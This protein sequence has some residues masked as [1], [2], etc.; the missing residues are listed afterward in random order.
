MPFDLPWE[1]LRL[2]SGMGIIAL[3]IYVIYRRLEVRLTLLVA[4]LLLGA[5]AED[6]PA[7]LRK[8]L[9]TFT[10]EKFVVPICTAMGF[11]YVVR[12]T[13]CD[14]HLVQLLL[15]PVKKVRPL[16][17]PGTV[18][19]GF[20]V[21]MPIVSQTST[22]VTIGMVVIPVLAAARISP[23]TIGAAL[24]L[25]CS[26][27]GELLNPGAPELR[28]TVVETEKAGAALVKAGVL[29]QP[30]PKL[31]SVDCVQRVLPLNLLGLAV[32]TAVFWFLAHRAEARNG[33]QLLI[34]DGQPP[35][36]SPGGRGQGE[37]GLVREGESAAPPAE[38]FRVNLL[39]ALVPLLPLLLLY[40]TAEPFQ[41]FD[42]WDWLQDPDTAERQD[43][44]LI[45]AS[46]LVGAAVA[47]LVVRH[48]AAGA[49]SAFFE[50]AGFGF[51]H[52]IS[53]IVAAS[54]F[55]EGIKMIGIA[56]VI[57]DVSREAP[58]LLLPAAGVLS[59][60]FGML[61]GSGMATAQSLFPFF[62]EATLRLDMDPAH[63]GAVVS[64][65]AAAGR[66]MS[67]VAAVVLM[68]ASMTKTDP[69]VLVKRVAPPLLAGML[70][71]IIA[72]ILLAPG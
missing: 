9:T 57:G 25:G 14:Q 71:I 46:M 38:P 68:C 3:T 23:A 2:L 47:A 44:R 18:V 51:T 29:Q 39:M 65:G 54:C 5:L 62:A 59:L 31:Q 37:G 21:N 45:G 67:P 16:L 63:V 64:L 58:Q 56:Q 28:T 22:A 10:D 24:L 11:A 53:L 48:K 15:Q 26:I 55:G 35:T 41:V 40:L 4:A 61:C 66:T 43:S 70:V 19:I 27:G 50:G 49:A 34:P 42:V 72:A 17:I 13:G 33:Q 1:E 12:H 7:I 6:A 60:G 8:F 69:L 32:A 52:I 30:P 20:L 36:L